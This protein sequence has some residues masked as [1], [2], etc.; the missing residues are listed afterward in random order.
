MARILKSLIVVALAMTFLGGTA[1]ADGRG[2]DRHH[3]DKWQSSHWKHDH[4]RARHHNHYR[5]HARAENRYDHRRR[6]V[7]V[8]PSRP[9][10]RHREYRASK[11]H[12]LAPRVIFLGGLP[13]P[14]PPPPNEVLDYLTGR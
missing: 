3:A 5:R 2:R 4:Y 9:D 13:V 12:P 14:V 8:V 7:R 1:M 11:P 6:H 10:Y